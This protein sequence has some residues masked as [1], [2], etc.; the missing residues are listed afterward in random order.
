MKKD[1]KSI[2]RHGDYSL[3]GKDSA[4]AVE[5]GLA[6]AKWFTPVVSREKMRALLVRRDGPAVRDT[7]LWFALLLFFGGCGILLWGSGWAVI[8][9]AIYGILYA[10]V[11]DS[12]WHECGHGTAFKSDWM[13]NALY[14]LA[15][16]MVV[17]ES[18]PWRWS[19]TRHHSDTL[20]VGLDPE[21][22]IQRPVNL[23]MVVLKFINFK[24]L[25]N[26]VRN[27]FLHCT[28][29]L[30]AD[31][32]TYIPL[33]EYG[34][35]FF[36]ARLYVLIYLAVAAL[37]IVTRSMLPLMLVGLPTFYGTWL[38]VIYGIS[39][40]A[41]LAEN[42]LD[43]RLNSRT[44]YM[45]PLNRYLYWNMNYHVE[46][47]IFPL[48]PY[49]ALPKLHALIK[50]DLPVPYNGL[51]EA[52]RE[53]IPTLIRQASDA[54]YY[55]KRP[56]PPPS[57]Q[58][59]ALNSALVINASGLALVDGWLEV[60]DS[61]LLIK[62]DVL[63]LDDGLKTY[64]IYRAADDRLY[65]TDGLC[66]HGNAHLADG[67]VKGTLIE[68]GKHNGRYDIRDG[69]PQ[70]LPVCVGIKT[71]PVRESAGK[72]LVNLSM[73][74]GY[75]VTRAAPT[76]TFRVVSN[77]N[78]AT[79]IKELVLEADGDSALPQYQPGDYLQVDIPAYAQRSLRGIEVETS[80]IATW[81]AQHVF[82]LSAAN[83]TSCRRN[84]SM[85]GNPDQDKTLR[86]NIRLA[87]PPRGV[88]CYAGTGSAYLFGLK[89]GDT[90]TAIGPFGEFHIKQ[91][92]REL[93]YLGGGAG[94]A[95]LRSHLSY[96][97]ESLGTT[98]PVSYWY[99]ARS[100]Q[101]MFYQDYFEELARK[102]GNFSFHAALSEPL[103]E[104]H[105]QSH[106]GFIHD[107]LK[108]EY[109]D[110]HPD[111]KSIDYFLCGPPAMIKAAKDMLAALGVDPL[112]IHFDEF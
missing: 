20:I 81:Q 17:R 76:H 28:G 54:E 71:Y 47:H 58:A 69:S 8:P 64:A 72:L 1:N 13:N 45:N 96:L 48:V 103:P 104:D 10:T 61:D 85:A 102:H 6:D 24:S 111:P 98:V 23:V 31:E 9:F 88:A 27:V 77:Q 59:A 32:R 15:S 50:A 19:H 35:V 68:C 39:Q 79:F 87:T 78:V 99:G 75:G 3:V 109:L 55:V 108:R 4:L 112:Q 36:R 91:S 110:G 90:L 26:Y 63:R 37:A 83:P 43:H 49:H 11:S 12:R 97:F 46:H 57:P 60:C 67:W 80:F 66:T 42:V 2:N 107:V 82:D 89:P 29:R 41:G 94:M 93:V 33:S 86:F 18:V 38:T 73:A 22:S 21:I 70:R 14:E 44:I 106:T 51:I 7:L 30:T 105:W 95:P 100:L 40:H 56:L 74:G 16:F 62:E 53:I 34:K 101:E 92:P 65:A 5:R 52:Y 84:Y 25:R